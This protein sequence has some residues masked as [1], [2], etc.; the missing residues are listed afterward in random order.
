PPQDQRR[1]VRA[2]SH[3]GERAA[4]REQLRL[5]HQVFEALRPHAVSERAF[6]VALGPA[7]G[8]KELAAHAQPYERSGR[9]PPTGS[10][11]GAVRAGATGE[12]RAS[13]GKPRPETAS[14]AGP[15]ASDASPTAARA[16]HVASACAA[17]STVIGRPSFTPSAS[18]R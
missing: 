18:R 1:E 3:Q 9:S 8:A 16:L 4:G 15:E 7:R 10:S 14:L 12:G 11:V 2:V 17:S 13:A 5:A 6:R